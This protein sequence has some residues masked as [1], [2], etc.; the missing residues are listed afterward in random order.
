V[1]PGAELYVRWLQSTVFSSHIRLHGAGERE[2]WIFGPETEAVCRKWLAFRYRLIPYLERVID[3]ATRTGLPVMRAMALAFPGNA[4]VRDFETQFLC[5]DALLVAP[6]L[7]E[8][9]DVDI[10]L[11]PGNWY[12]LNTRQRFA[13]R[14]VIRYR[15]KIDQ[16]PVF[17]REGY[18]LPLG[19][20]V[21][22]TGEIDADNPLE[23]LWVFGTPAAALDGF[24]Q[25]RVEDGT[26]RAASGLKVEFFGEP[27]QKAS[28][29]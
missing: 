6:V 5:G 7:R 27:G 24:A 8:G 9:G 26:V 23:M 22:H 28:P 4:L 14:Q 3:E 15:A 16:F 29:L 21:Q 1:Q 11:P 20:A 18:A 19:R 12:D 17:G 2:P 10:A 25:A 13:G